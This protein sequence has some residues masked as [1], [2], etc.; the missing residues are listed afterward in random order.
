MDE[1]LGCDSETKWHLN[2]YV[3]VQKCLSQCADRYMEATNFV[4]KTL[5]QRLEQAQHQGGGNLGKL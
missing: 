1:V 4:G 5:I 2:V 3:S